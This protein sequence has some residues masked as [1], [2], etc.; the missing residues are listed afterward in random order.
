MTRFGLRL[1]L[2]LLQLLTS[3]AAWA[4]PHV[5]VTARAEVQFDGDGRISG[6]RHAWTFDPANSSFMTQG[7]DTNHD[8]KLTSGELKDLARENALSLAEFDYFTVLKANGHRQEFSEP[9]QYD[10]TFAD[11]AL[12]LNYVLP[13]RSPADPGKTVSVEIY[14]PTYF[15]SLSMAPDNPVTLARAPRGCTVR[16]TGAKGLKP[17]TAQ[18]PQ[19]LSEAFFLALTSTANYGAQFANRVQITCP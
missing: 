18:P 6:V 9:D 7:L 4:H 5:W 16:V 8:G 3:G 2:G 11:G 13:L 14:D 15:V 19:Q 17:L 12:T 1:V 10:M